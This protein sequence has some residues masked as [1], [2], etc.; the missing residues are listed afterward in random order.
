VGGHA[1]RSGQLPDG[2]PSPHTHPAPDTTAALRNYDTKTH[3]KQDRD[4]NAWLQVPLLRLYSALF[5]LYSG[6]IKAK[7][8]RDNTW[9]HVPLVYE[10][11]YLSYTQTTHTSITKQVGHPADPADVFRGR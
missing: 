11:V 6:S 4:D 2:L 1:R 10:V 9:L 8:D 7:Q 3:E 5:R